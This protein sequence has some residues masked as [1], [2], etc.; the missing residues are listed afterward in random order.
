MCAA[1]ADV[2][3]GPKA[4]SRSAVGSPLSP[5]GHQP[6]RRTKSSVAP[7]PHMTAPDACRVLAMHDG[8]PRSAA[9]YLAAQ[10]LTIKSTLGVERNRDEREHDELPGDVRGRVHK[11][12]DE[13]EK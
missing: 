10:K 3:Y 12:R 5:P 13:S 4:T 2:D 9:L 1:P 7:N 11:L 6:E 8:R